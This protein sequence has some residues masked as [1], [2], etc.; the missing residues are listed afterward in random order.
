MATKTAIN[1]VENK[2][3]SVNNLITD[4]NTKINE[5]EKNTDHDH[6]KYITTLEFNKLTSENIA[7]RLKQKNVASLSDIAN[8]VN[9][10]DFDK[11]KIKD[12]TSK[13]N[14]LNELLKKVKAI[15]TK[16]LTKDLINKFSILKG[17]KMFFLRNIS[18]LFGIYTG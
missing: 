8:F 6:D 2:I 12:V 3:P 14:E 15:A 7:A 10:T 18:E 13:K 1:A 5:I 11:K 16:G 17:S 4:Y 9:K